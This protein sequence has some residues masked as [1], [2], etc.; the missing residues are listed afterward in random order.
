M[1]DLG[2]IALVEN[3]P[4]SVVEMGLVGCGIGDEGGKALLN[5]MTQSPNLKM[6]CIENNDFSA[7]MIKQFHELSAQKPYMMLVV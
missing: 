5:W 4:Q 1:G 2:T 6:V 7:D 3:L